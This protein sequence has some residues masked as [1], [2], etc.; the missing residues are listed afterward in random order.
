MSEYFCNI[1]NCKLNFKNL[2]LN[3]WLLPIQTRLNCLLKK[4][5]VT[6]DFINLGCLSISL[7]IFM[8]NIIV[9]LCTLNSLTN[10]I[11]FS[12]SLKRLKPFPWWYTMDMI[13]FFF[14]QIISLYCFI[15]SAAPSGLS[16]LLTFSFN[17]SVSIISLF[18]M[19][20]IINCFFISPLLSHLGF[21]V[22]SEPPH[23]YK[24]KITTIP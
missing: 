10:L 22:F 1:I 14:V 17:S 18:S 13:T 21:L 23:S 8:L 15:M 11:N 3:K 5:N 12:Y 16:T 4:C 6:D 19:E 7:K 9:L 2:L 20:S 24:Q